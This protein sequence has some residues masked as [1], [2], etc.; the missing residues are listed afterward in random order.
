MALRWSNIKGRFVPESIFHNTR[1]KYPQ[2]SDSSSW[3]YYKGFEPCTG[4]CND[5]P[6]SGTISVQ[7]LTANCVCIT[8]ILS[9]NISVPSFSSVTQRGKQAAPFHYYPLIVFP[10]IHGRIL[11]FFQWPHLNAAKSQERSD[12]F[13]ADVGGEILVNERIYRITESFEME[14]TCKG[15][16]VQLEWWV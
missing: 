3:W 10:V 5:S 7:R 15:H 13:V 2:N 8:F 11:I 16:L 4:L 14:E 1:K 12:K 6:A 9:F